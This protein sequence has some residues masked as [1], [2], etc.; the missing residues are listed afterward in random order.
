LI[1]DSE[2]H[3]EMEASTMKK[4]ANP[5]PAVN[6]KKLNWPHISDLPVG[7]VGGNIDL[8]IGLDYA[9]L[10]VV[11]ESR[12]EEAGQPIASHTKFGWII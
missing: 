11:R 3:F 1:K 10:L 4:V 6:W 5:A 2:D 12:G 9:H 7:E 8:L